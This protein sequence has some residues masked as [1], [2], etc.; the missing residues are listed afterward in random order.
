MPKVSHT[1]TL[2]AAPMGDTGPDLINSAN[3]Q[4]DLETTSVLGSGA[5]ETNAAMHQTGEMAPLNDHDSLK[6]AH[7]GDHTVTSRS[8]ETT[9]DM[10]QAGQADQAGSFTQIIDSMGNHHA[11]KVDDVLKTS[12][13]TDTFHFGHAK[14]STV[15]SSHASDLNSNADYAAVADVGGFVQADPGTA[16]VGHGLAFAGDGDGE[17]KNPGSSPDKLALHPDHIVVVIEENHDQDQIIGNPNAPYING[18]LVKDGLYYSNAHGT[19]HPS[20]PNYLELFS[21]VNPGVQ[22]VNS[23]LQQHYPAG[24][25]GTPASQ[26]ALNHGDD[27]N[28]GQPFSVPNLGAELLAAGKSFAGYSED[29]PSVGFTGAQTNG[30][31]GNR[32]YVEKHNPWA[33]FEGNGSNQLPADTNQPLTTFQSISDF[34]KLPNVSFVVPNE[35]NDMH[36]TVSK[37]G[38]YAVGQTGLDNFGNPVN[39][40]ST[41]QNGDTWLSNNIEAYREWA[42]THNSLLVTVWDENDFDFSNPNNIPMVIDGDPRLVQPGVNSSDVNHFDLLKTLESFYG[43]APTGLAATAEGLPANGKLLPDP[44]VGP[45]HVFDPSKGDTAPD[46]LT[47]GDNHLFAAYANGVASDGTGKGTSEIVEYDLNGHIVHTYDIK[48]SVDGLKFDPSTEKVWALQNQDGNSTLTLIDP[49]THHVSKPLAYDDTSASRGYDDV[50][51]QGG[52]AFLSYTNPVNPGDAVIVK[53]D[54]GDHPKGELETTPV[55]KFGAI[56]TNTVTHQ[57]GQIVPLNDPDSLK[58]APNGDLLLSSGDDGTIVDVHHAGQ[59]DQAVSFTQITDSMGNPVA[60]LDDV[61]KTNAEAGTFYLTDTTTNTVE[62]FHVSN[63]N[64]NDYYASV[65][66][67]GGFGQVDPSTGKF[68]LLLAAPGAHGLAFTADGD[69]QAGK[70]GFDPHNDAF[71]FNQGGP[72]HPGNAQPGI[73]DVTVSNLAQLLEAPIRRASIP[74]RRRASTPMQSCLNRRSLTRTSTDSTSYRHVRGRES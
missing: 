49:D 69:S 65:S 55:L 74:A 57:T 18:T 34:S 67:L 22:G 23:P 50:V 31:N 36:D 16:P 1:A 62:S 4:G 64:P 44:V 8:D 61:I 5:T 3:P 72:N 25:E 45:A 11:T 53:L 2:A 71:V 27:Y 12:V 32:S 56:G 70:P 14:G 20:Q 48:G 33:Q 17:S 28:T 9:V 30:I 43:L 6:T 42:T 19:D 37:V 52:K 41:I 7:I 13:E 40:D 15:Q 51:F 21:G 58:A 26:N 73:P 38:L 35:Y 60:G 68:T 39:G 66:G 47:I 59:A 63:L 54:G 24:T 46:S 10:H 29:L